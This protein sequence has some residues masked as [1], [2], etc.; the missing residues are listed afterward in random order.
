MPNALIG[1]TGFVGGNLARQMPFDDLFH[2]R[3]IADIRGR[4]YD[5][6]VCAGVRAEKWK[7]NADPI[8]D[9]VGILS[10]FDHLCHAAARRLVLISTVDVYPDP[11]NVNEDSLIDPAAASAYGRHRYEL[12]RELSGR[13]DTTVIR[14]PGLFG[15]GL[16]KN[17]IFDLLNDNLVERIHPAGVFQY[18]NLDR[19][20]ADI[21]TSLRHEL[22]VVNFATEPIATAELAH[23]VFGREL[24][25][26]PGS[27]GR[28]NFRSKYADRFGGRDGYLY[29]KDRVLADLKRF[30]AAYPA[31]KGAA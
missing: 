28:Y 6:I 1:C 18:Y 16:K 14:L 29:S 12:E 5:T 2:S 19:L 21:E 30:V 27:A 8:S 20:A 25:A 24:P 13:F 4:S 9:R 23:T 22:N 31:R 11:V 3:N 7:A 26:K 17:V 10:L 15:D